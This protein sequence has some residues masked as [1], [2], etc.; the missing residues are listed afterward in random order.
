MTPVHETPASIL[1]QAKALFAEER[2]I[3]RLDGWFLAREIAMR[4]HLETPEEPAV[5]QAGHALKRIV[6]QLPLSLSENAVFAGTQR[7]AFAK[8]YALINPNFR[9]S[10]FNGYCDPTA[11]F[12]DIEPN[13]E[14]PAERI[15][16]V[17][18]WSK[19]TPY[20]TQLSRVYAAAERDTAEVAYFVEQVTGHLIP[21]FRPALRTGLEPMLAALRA[22]NGAQW[23][24]T[25]ARLGEG[26]VRAGDKAYAPAAPVRDWKSLLLWAV[27]V[28]G[29]LAVAGF[30]IS[31]LRGARPANG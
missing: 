6:E 14:F 8:S 13:A 21:D 26:T 29:A 10:T 17:R 22:R 15:E 1:E 28:A 19:T 27:L 18:E 25:V 11:V 9:V 24:P 5:L 20:V 31:L 30:A 12:N 23:Q 7:D 4:S 16:R 2:A 3:H